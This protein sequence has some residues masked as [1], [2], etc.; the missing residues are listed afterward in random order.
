MLVKLKF[1]EKISVLKTGLLRGSQYSILSL[2]L[3]DR[4]AKVTATELLLLSTRI[5]PLPKAYNFLSLIAL[6]ENSQGK[7]AEFL[8]Q[9]LQLD[10]KQARVHG[11]L[12]T[13]LNPCYSYN[14]RLSGYRRFRD[15]IA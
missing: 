11:G 4:G 13:Y 10:D 6:R 7:A 2:N 3:Y 8:E 12:G 1:Q 15:P 9:S 14:Q 5:H